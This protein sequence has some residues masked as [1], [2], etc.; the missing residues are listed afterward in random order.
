VPD[1]VEARRFAEA[2]KMADEGIALM[3]QNFCRR[4]P[5]ADDAEIDRLL[6]EWLADRPLDAPGRVVPG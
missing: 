6:G 2:V 4:H 1:S 3:R 5:D